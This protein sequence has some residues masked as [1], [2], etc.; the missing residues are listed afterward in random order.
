M[1]TLDIHSFKESGIELHA[2]L[3]ISTL[4]VSSN[5]LVLRG[6]TGMLKNVSDVNLLDNAP[7]RIDMMLMIDD[8]NPSLVII[9]DDEAGSDPPSILET[10]RLARHEY[11][12]LNILMLINNQDFDKELS[13]LRFGIR[14]ILSQNFNKKKPDG[15]H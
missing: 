14:G 8:L 6:I 2:E 7:S 1:G 15:L 12:N 13:A 11:P 9:N 10:V 5:T 3:P 4:L